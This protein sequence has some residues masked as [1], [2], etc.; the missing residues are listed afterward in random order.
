MSAIDLAVKPCKKCGRTLPLSNFYGDKNTR[1]RLR[2]DCKECVSAYMK[3]R[4]QRLRE[5][6]GEEAY[7]ASEAAKV[8]EWRK[9]TGDQSGKKY[10]AAKNR[11]TAKL[12]DAHRR[13]FDHLLAIEMRGES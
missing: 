4:A 1:D 9:R 8:R 10:R 6:M 11:A 12:I 3:E 5:E 2:G 7:R 13:Q